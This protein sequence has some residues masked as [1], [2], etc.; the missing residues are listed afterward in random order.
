[1]EWA[2]RNFENKKII[3]KGETIDKAKVWLGETGT[4]EMVAA[5]DVTVVLPR[6]NRAD[7][8]LTVKYNEPLK[9]PIKQGDEVG[10]LLIDVP[11]QKT[12]TL[13]LLAGRE[14]LRKGMFGRFKDRLGYLVSGSY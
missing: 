6:A 10:E 9:A 12:S 14:E 13:K 7:L 3:S 4:V 2:F 5:N 8:K 1:M 11:G